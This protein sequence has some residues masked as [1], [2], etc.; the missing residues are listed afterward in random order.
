MT[1]NNTVTYPFSR[2]VIIY[3]PVSTGDSV[4]DAESLQSQLRSRLPT[5]VAIDLKATEYTGHGEKI[6]YE[7]AEPSGRTLLIS[8]SGDGGYHEVINGL[9][10][11][12]NTDLATVVMPSGNANDHHHATAA[13]EFLD[14]IVAGKIRYIDALEVR[15]RLRG[16]TWSRYAHSYIGVGM[17]PYIGKRLNKT[18]LN[19]VNEKWL[20]LKY[21]IKFGHATLK[22]DDEKRWRRYSNLLV[23]NIDRMSKVIKL[24]D[25]A[26]VDDGRFEVYR[27]Y[28]QPTVQTLKTVF[29]GAV[30][31]LEPAA[32]A[33]R[34]SFVSKQ[35]GELQCDGEI[36]DFD[37]GQPVEI[38]IHKQ[39]IKTLA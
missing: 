19:P 24:S 1:Y 18:E 31:G 20:V 33:D 6:A 8:A 38:G 34:L 27:T 35:N 37:G 29:V 26:E 28:R 5:D 14:R 22:V 4:V 30:F 11:S 16:K 32:Q 21:M 3:N 2:I 9:L 25:A 23:A 12:A 15:S 36:Y 17:T 39:R 10:K 7:C 13:A